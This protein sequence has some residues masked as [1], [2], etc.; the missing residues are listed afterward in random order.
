MRVRP[1]PGARVHL[2]HRLLGSRRQVRASD[3]RPVPD[4]GLTHGRAV[5]AA[6]ALLLAAAW[7]CGGE[8]GPAPSTAASD[9]PL[10]ASVVY[11]G[12]ELGRPSDLAVN[13]ERLLVLDMIGTAPL[14]LI[15]LRSGERLASFGRSGEG[16]GEF[17]S[18]RNAQ[19]ARPGVFW[20]YDIELKRLTRVDTDRVLADSA[21]LGEG[22]ILFRDGVLPMSPTVV[23]REIVSPGIFPRGRLGVFDSLGTLRKTMAELPPV[24][25]AEPPHGVLQHAWTGTLVAHPE[26]T[27]MALAAR[28]ADRIDL[29]RADG[30]LAASARGEERF[31]PVFQVQTRNGTPY[32]ATGEDLRFGYIDLWPTAD[33]IFA[34][35][36]GRTRRDFPGK[37]SYGDEVHVFDWRGRLLRAFKLESETLAIATDPDG[38]TLYAL[39]EDPTPA[40]VRYDLPP[41]P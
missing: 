38:G 22:S 37:A 39:R 4:P 30:S 15:D 33:R 18:V 34:L 11:D 3:R 7:G 10:R 26:G 21:S 35:Y 20:V 24:S 16:P 29:Y 17:R 1:L 13:G 32:M 25:G 8:E 19:P 27:L 40:V 36:S 12:D 6:A 2:H 41:E 23:G 31:D 28:H 5:R 14:H 9:T